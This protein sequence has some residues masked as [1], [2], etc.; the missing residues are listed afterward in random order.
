[1]GL[2]STAMADID[3]NFDGE[4]V[5]YY[6]TNDSSNNDFLSQER[7]SA[8]VGLQ[9]DLKSDLGNDFGLAYQETF[10]GTLGLEKNLVKGVRQYAKDKKINAH[11]M[12]KLYMTK[13]ID[14][15]FLKLGR[16]ELP[17]SLSPL[18]FSESWNLTFPTQT[19]KEK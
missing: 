15:T 3:F 13:K 2:F 4:G 10:L 11:T 19:P 16:Q 18:A 5:L 7:S 9:L 12:T 14:N 1:M 6:Q 17:K 8:N